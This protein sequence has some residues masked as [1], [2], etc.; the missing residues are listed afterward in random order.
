MSDFI[1]TIRVENDLVGPERTLR[2]SCLLNLLQQAAIHHTE[3]L[4]MGREKTLDRGLLWAISRQQI[5]IDRMPAY[6]ERVVLTSWPG[7]TMHVLFPRYCELRTQEGERLLRAS[8]LWVLLDAGTRSFVFP[9]E[10][11]VELPGMDRA[12]QLPLPEQPVSL[13]SAS[14][15]QFTVPYSYVDLNGHMNNT[16]YLDLAEDLLPEDARTRP[17]AEIRIAHQLE[18]RC[19]QTLTVSMGADETVRTF[20]GRLEKPVFQLSLRYRS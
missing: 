7:R 2:P 1:E 11:G 10:Y 9:D 13:P 12:D 19:G 17:L 6:D 14:E 20:T 4:G 15:T 8:A 3:Q 16:R 5:V 18:A